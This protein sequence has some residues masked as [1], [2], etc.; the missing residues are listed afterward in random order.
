[1]W[2]L[3]NMRKRYLWLLIGALAMALAA[4][5]ACETTTEDA[6]VSVADL[7]SDAAA[8]V[9][10]STATWFVTSAWTKCTT[11]RPVK[12][13]WAGTLRRYD[14]GWMH[15]AQMPGTD[16]PEQGHYIPNQITSQQN[17]PLRTAYQIAGCDVVSPNAKV[18][19]SG[20]AQ[21]FTPPTDKSL[22]R[23]W[24]P[25]PGFTSGS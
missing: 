14:L 8:T 7:T 17:W 23:R 18:Y 12:K 2:R 5:F 10:V 6:D 11:L 24:Q 3:K 21:T 19:G 1:M 25:A 20:T 13:D 15:Y 4:V 22:N 9:G 16:D